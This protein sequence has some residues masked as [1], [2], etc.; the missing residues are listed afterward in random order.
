MRPS[1]ADSSSSTEPTVP[2]FRLERLIGRGATTTVY[3]ATQLSLDRRVAV[4]LFP[5]GPGIEQRV[6]RLRWPEHPNVV[7]LYAAGPCEHGYFVAMQLIDGTSLA[8]RK[9]GRARTLRVLRDVG[10]ALDAA[11]AAGVV[12]GGLTARSVLVDQG[13]RGFLS[14]FGLGLV[15]ATPASDRAAFAA[16]VHDCLGGEPP[17]LE[18][19]AAA[20]V[21]SAEGALPR[22]RRWAW[23]A[24]AVGVAAT[25]GMVVAID[26]NEPEQAPPLLHGAAAIGSPLPTDGVRS[27][28]CSGRP[29]SGAAEP[30]GLI[31]TR[32]QGRPVTPGSG[33]VVRRWEVRGARGELALQVLRRHGDSLFMVARTPY[34][35][36]PDEGLHVLPANLPVRAGDLVGLSVAPGATVGVRDAGGAAVARRFGPAD[37]SAERFERGFDEELLL[38]VE[39]VPGASWRPAGLLTGQAAAR[40]AAGR[41]LDALEPEPGVRLAAVSVA[42]R[43]VVDLHSRGRRVARLSVRD[44]D[45]AGRLGSLTTQRVRLGKTIVRLSWRNP[46]GLVSHYYAV[47]AR[48]LAPLD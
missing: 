1:R 20:I 41:E 43:I 3:E 34:L 9:L 30:C 35:A 38:R 14:D 10:A 26:S 21:R 8:E 44:A 24:A 22:R 36:V 45:P 2:G 47:G 37:V 40:A 17:A 4:K 7:S 18:A 23:A 16:L 46:D 15:D 42:G 32:L 19:S 29:P 48:S 39:Y 13:G 27:V 31:Q 33:G 28:D 5:K 12:H 6:R 25:A 11:H